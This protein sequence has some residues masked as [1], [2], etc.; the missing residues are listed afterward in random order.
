[1]DKGLR[2][3]LFVLIVAAGPRQAAAQE[4]VC[5][6][7]R[8]GDTAGK[9]ALRLTGSTDNLYAPWFRIVD[10]HARSIPKSQYA[11][12]LP[13]WRVCVTRPYAAAQP[14]VISVA[15]HRPSI[16]PSA[17]GVAQHRPPI[18][19]VAIGVAQHRLPIDP[20][21]LRYGAAVLILVAALLAFLVT[22]QILSEREAILN[23]M[24]WFGE[25]FVGEFERPLFQYPV[26][27]RADRRVADHPVRS[28]L[29]FAPRRDRLE[30]LLAPHD[31]RTYPNLSDHRKNL[32]YD[33][34]RVLHLLGDQPFRSGRL[35]AEG[36][37]VVI[38]FRLRTG[39][40]S[41]RVTNEDGVK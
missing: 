18:D 2:A 29:R 5:Y 30:I 1:V 40:G 12:I 31:G 22:M 23:R 11:K 21:F 37:W 16:D 17:I 26:A 7:V 41:P 24:R 33:I 36:R 20:M 35:H 34:E 13:G 32:E 8:P 14:V 38:P 3:L 10:A 4:V 27:R 15:Q 6:P 25:R 28:R 19:A 39:Y 9:F